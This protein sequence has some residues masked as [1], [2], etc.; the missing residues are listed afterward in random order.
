[1]GHLLLITG[2]SGPDFGKSDG[3]AKDFPRRQNKITNDL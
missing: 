3:P 1:M 2:S